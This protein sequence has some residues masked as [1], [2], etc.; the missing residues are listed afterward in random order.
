MRTT[1]PHLDAIDKIVQEYIPP[2]GPGAAVAVTRAGQLIHSAGYGMASLE[3][4]Q[5]VT[6]DTVFG[7]GSTTKPFTATAILMLERD[8]LLST[9]APLTDY[10]P[11]Y[12]THGAAITLTHL[13][14]HTSGIPNFIT[15]PGF[16]ESVAP[17]EHDHAR[18]RALFEPLPLDFAPGERYSYS[19]SGYC[20]LGM[21]IET[22]LP[23]AL[24]GLHSRAHL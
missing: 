18:L 9:S 8:G 15:R 11:G 6:P 14:T 13:L 3:W 22:R 12:D 4:G 21:I 7:I 19:N 10:L 2:G 16:W 5:L 23:H 17:L 24:P 1:S 20:L